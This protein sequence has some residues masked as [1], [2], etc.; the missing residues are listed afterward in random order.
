MSYESNPAPDFEVQ[1]R[2]RGY[3]YVLCKR[4][5]LGAKFNSDMRGEEHTDRPHGEKYSPSI[6]EGDLYECIE[7]NANI[8][9]IE[10]QEMWR[11]RERRF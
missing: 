7:C 8:T 3:M 1:E 6:Y 2:T 5:G 4:C 10:L 11:K 9:S